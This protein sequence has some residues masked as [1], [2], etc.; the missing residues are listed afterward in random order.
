MKN[1]VIIFGGLLIS[2]SFLEAKQIGSGEDLNWLTQAERFIEMKDPS[3][4]KVALGALLMGLSCGLI[5]SYVVTR[6]LSLFGDTLSHA[7]LPGIAVGFIWAG[8]KENFS[9]LIGAGIAGFAGV[10]CLSLLK[11]FTKIHEDSSLG[12]VLSAFYALGICLLTRIQKVGYTDQSGLDSFMFGQVTSLSSGDI[13]SLLI[14]LLLIGLFITINFRQLLVTGFDPQFSKSIGIPNDFLQFLLWML[15]AFC[16]ISSLQ[17]VGVILVSAMLVIPA[18][19]ASLFAKRLKNYLVLSSLL[20]A[21]AGISGTFFSFLGKGLPA[22]P[23]IV[24]F[25]AFLF[26]VILFLRPEKGIIVCWLKA[27]SE[28]SRIIIENTLKATFKILEQKDFQENEITSLE[29]MKKRGLSRREVERE[30]DKLASSGFC[31]KN[32]SA[33]DE[34]NLPPQTV[35]ILTPKGWEYACKIVRNHRLWELYLT[36]E[37]QYEPD[38]VHEDAEKIEHVL[39][40]KTVRQIE[41]LLKNPKLDPHGKFIPSITDIHQGN[42][43]RPS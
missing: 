7:V 22:G 9:L 1:W 16:V 41:R 15:I 32:L 21:G 33:N 34:A 35:M 11:K 20:G 43:P 2:S 28:R 37:A 31:T 24:L 8:E 23:L 17:L 4:R 38:H 36:N 42:L 6:R 39:G 14:T 29:I 27:R 40:E 26:L 10:C 30:I 25:S 5:G 12:I 18:A 19:T 3:I 13:I